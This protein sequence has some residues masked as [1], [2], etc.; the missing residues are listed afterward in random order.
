MKNVKNKQKLDRRDTYTP[1]GA[2]QACG[3]CDPLQ[4][5]VLKSLNREETLSVPD[6]K[7]P[8]N[9]PDVDIRSGMTGRGLRVPIINMYNETLMPTTSGKAGKLL[10]KGKAKVVWILICHY[11]HGCLL[12]RSY[13]M[14]NKSG[15]S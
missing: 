4:N 5:G 1:T 3:N 2:P 9:N 11:L 14:V 15:I 7:T 10:N 6:L 12:L 8:S 13:Y